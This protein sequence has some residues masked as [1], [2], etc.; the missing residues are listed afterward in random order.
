MFKKWFDRDLASAKAYHSAQLHAAGNLEMVNALRG[1]LD[2][3]S[4]LERLIN[5]LIDAVKPNPEKTSPVRSAGGLFL[6]IA[7]NV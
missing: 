2:E 6:E 3:S 1:G 7:K 4:L 5:R